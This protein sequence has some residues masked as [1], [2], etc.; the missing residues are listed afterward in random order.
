MERSLRMSNLHYPQ[1]CALARAAELIGERWTLLIIRE[2]LL[3][4]KRFGDILDH[5][6]GISPTLLTARLAALIDSKVVSQNH[7]AEAVKCP[8]LRANRHWTRNS[9][10]NPGVDPFGVVIFCFLRCP[11]IHSSRTGCFSASMPSQG[12]A[13]TGSQHRPCRDHGRKS[14]RLYDR[15]RSERNNYPE[16]RGLQ[17]DAGSAVRCCPADRGHERI[18][19]RRNGGETRQGHRFDGAR[20][21]AAATIRPCRAQR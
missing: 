19:R 11:A 10:G 16:G 2:L 8:A 14:G 20:S 3:G 5:L 21:Q 12:R 6:D 9:A 7:N 15:R 4:P 17:D 1:F 18:T 13:R